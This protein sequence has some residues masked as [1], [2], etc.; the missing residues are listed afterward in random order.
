MSTANLRIRQGDAVELETKL[1]YAISNYKF[2][3]HDWAPALAA[4]K[5]R[6]ANWTVP[7]LR[8]LRNRVVVLFWAG[9]DDG[10]TTL[11]DIWERTETNLSLVN[12]TCY[13]KLFVLLNRVSIT[14]IACS[15][16]KTAW[17]PE[18]RH[19]SNTSFLITGLAAHHLNRLIWLFGIVFLFF[20]ILEE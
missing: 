19:C 8:H 5:N 4:Q 14:S 13:N 15:D 16:W 10:S 9:G 7:A 18:T 12:F 2:R 1:N 20:N 17:K 3:D 6:P 11:P